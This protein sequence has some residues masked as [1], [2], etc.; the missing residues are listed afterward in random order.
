[1]GWLSVVCATMLKWWNQHVTGVGSVIKRATPLSNNY[2]VREILNKKTKQTNPSRHKHRVSPISSRQYTLSVY[3]GGISRCFI[4]SLRP[5][6]EINTT[7]G[8]W[9]IH[10]GEGGNRLMSNLKLIFWTGYCILSILLLVL[11]YRGGP[12]S[13]LIQQLNPIGDWQSQVM[14]AGTG[15]S[16]KQLAGWNNVQH[17][18]RLHRRQ[19]ASSEMK[20]FYSR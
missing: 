13:Q 15:D 14:V 20:I 19:G 2:K 12:D 16:Q 8:H 17:V 10:H 7:T 9:L 1:M 5:K 18:S 4:T 6:W 3:T 11:P